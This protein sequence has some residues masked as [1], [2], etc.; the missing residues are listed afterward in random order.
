MYLKQ[1]EDD[2]VEP[3]E[4]KGSKNWLAGFKRR[5]ANWGHPLVMKRAHIR[6]SIGPTRTRYQ[7][8]LIELW[9]VINKYICHD[10]N[11][12]IPFANEVAKQAH[13]KSCIINVDETG[14][15]RVNAT[16]LHV[17]VPP[18]SDGAVGAAPSTMDHITMVG[19]CDATGKATPLYLILK[20]DPDKV[21]NTLLQRMA[22][23]VPG[24]GYSVSK[25]G[26]MTDRIWLH[27][28]KYIIAYKQPTHDK[29]M[30]IIVDNHISRY[31]M[32]AIQY[33]RDN[34][35]HIITMLPNATSIGQP[36]DIS[37]YGH[38][39]QQLRNVWQMPW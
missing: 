20:G 36:L 34:H 29:P 8:W 39:K 4:W 22:S 10:A 18:N 16:S 24:V 14:I 35:C 38:S 26:W 27:Y 5:V 19:G 25:K 32:D 33:A 37:V 3:K 12:P 28:I 21:N 11:G 17:M 13:I 2:N 7:Q 1:C 23:A 15:A 9:N 30:I 31:N 6:S